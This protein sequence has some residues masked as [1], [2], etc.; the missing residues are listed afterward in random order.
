MLG[1]YEHAVGESVREHVVFPAFSVIL[2]ACTKS[3]KVQTLQHVRC[4]SKQG[5]AYSYREQNESVNLRQGRDGLT[6]EQ[7]VSNH[8]KG[9]P[10]RNRDVE[11]HFRNMY[12]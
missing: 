6:K 3:M 1:K 12:R 5:H 8:E 10:E 2:V 9:M 4:C 7:Q 11:S